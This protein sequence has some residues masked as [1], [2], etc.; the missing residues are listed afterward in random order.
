M[1]RSSCWSRTATATAPCASI[2]TTG[3]AIH[4][5]SGTRALPRG[6]IRSWSRGSRAFLLDS[7]PAI[8]AIRGSTQ[9]RQDTDILGIQYPRTRWIVNFSAWIIGDGKDVLRRYGALCERHPAGPAAALG[10]PSEQNR[11]CLDKPGHD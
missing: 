3:C 9:T 6:S 1:R 4:I 8:I 7:R 2:T 5:W 10:A 11:G